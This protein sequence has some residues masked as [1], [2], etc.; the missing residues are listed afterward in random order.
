MSEWE[1]PPRKEAGSDGVG[2]V[3]A[4]EDVEQEIIRKLAEPI[5]Y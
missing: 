5:R 2:R 4:I 1:H 3:E